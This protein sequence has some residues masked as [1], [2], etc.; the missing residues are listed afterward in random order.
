MDCAI[1]DF[2]IRKILFVQKGLCR[3]SEIGIDLFASTYS[4]VHI[5][6]KNFFTKNLVFI[7]LQEKVTVARIH[8]NK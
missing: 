3:G 8:T 1:L 4:V 2:C 7:F 6:L 5:Y